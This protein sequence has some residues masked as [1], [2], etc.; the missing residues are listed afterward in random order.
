MYAQKVADANTRVRVGAGAIV[1]D[2]RGWILLEKR[3]DCGWWGLPGGRIEPGESVKEAAVREVKEETGLNIEITQLLG[4]YSDPAE[5]R[6][7]TFLD[8]GDV[9]HLVDIIVEAKI[10]SGELEISSESEALQF[11]N[12]AALPPEIVPPALAPLQDFL[13]KLTGTLR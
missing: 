8:N 5:S 13:Q 1:L 3:S 10:I 9:V 6:I 12:P 11:F 2:N 7:V 4:V